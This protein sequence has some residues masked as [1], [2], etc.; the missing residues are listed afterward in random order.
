MPVKT[1]D[2]K[3]VVELLNKGFKDINTLSKEER[4]IL[5]VENNDFAVKQEVL[6]DLVEKKDRYKSMKSLIDVIPVTEDSG[7]YSSSDNESTGE[8]VLIEATE[9]NPFPSIPV[10]QNKLEGFNWKVKKYAAV[11]RISSELIED[12]QENFTKFFATLHDKKQARTENKV[13]FATMAEGITPEAVGVEGF[14][15]GLDNDINASYEAS[16]SV[17]TNQDGL[18]Q[19]RKLPQY[20]VIDT[21]EGVKRYFDIYPLEVFSNDEL[22]NLETGTPIFYGSFK[23]SVKLF[24][25]DLKIKATEKVDFLKAMTH[26]RGIINFD[27]KKFD[28]PN[29]EYKLLPLIS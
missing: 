20:S 6:T 8:M 29:Y 11:S 4:A 18:K 10:Q 26:I 24:E 15:D 5:N 3:K 23:D 17:V 28:S 12:S 27:V 21:D 13:I 1:I 2:N 22:P 16:A 7:V 14:V 25:Q 19:L 9:E